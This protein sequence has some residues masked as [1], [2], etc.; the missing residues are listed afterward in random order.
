MQ[1]SNV[2]YFLAGLLVAG[3]I[4][5]AVA[6]PFGGH[7]PQPGDMNQPD[8][9]MMDGFHRP[10]MMGH[11]GQWRHDPAHSAIADLHGIERLYVLNGR[12]NDLGTLYKH[13]LDKT[14]N[15][16][17]RRYVYRHLARS[18]MKPANVDQAIATLQKGL[19][20]DLARL[21]ASKKD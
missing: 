1:R 2:V 19:D 11:G 16:E 10:G 20:E 3:S 7:G 18:E 8:M 21:N 15:P 17:V 14:Q 12:V 9:P 6:E 5:L 13:V 4:S